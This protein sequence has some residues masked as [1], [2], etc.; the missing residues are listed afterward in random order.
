[1]LLMSKMQVEL[2]SEQPVGFGFP[3]SLVWLGS[4]PTG[5]V[6]FALTVV[7]LQ[8]SLEV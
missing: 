7:R 8:D 3:L 6:D 5:E 4:M 2:G 1:M